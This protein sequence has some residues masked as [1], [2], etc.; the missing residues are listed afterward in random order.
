MRKDYVYDD[1]VPNE[2]VRMGRCGS[3]IGAGILRGARHQDLATRIRLAV[4]QR[5][6]PPWR[7]AP[8]DLVTQPQ[9]L[10]SAKAKLDL[11]AQLKG[12]LAGGANDLI[13]NLV[14]HHGF[15]GTPS[16]RHR[17]GLTDHSSV[18]NLACTIDA[19]KEH[20]HQSGMLPVV[21]GGIERRLM[22]SMAAAERAVSVQGVPGKTT[23]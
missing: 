12:Q 15:L 16:K 7:I 21:R 14:V 10:P 17:V 4:N 8:A 2:D 23:N 6:Y 22:T 18:A 13:D 1:V 20:R 11:G 9:E 19:A 3:A 5:R